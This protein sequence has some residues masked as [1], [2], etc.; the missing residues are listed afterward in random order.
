MATYK[1]ENAKALL[2][3]AKVAAKNTDLVF[4]IVGTDWTKDGESFSMERKQVTKDM[5]KAPEFSWKLD[6]ATGVGTLTLAEGK[7]GRRPSQGA[8]EDEVEDAIARAME[9]ED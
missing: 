9:D 6:K 4:T 3:S 8:S 5:V 2:P 1:V 7:R